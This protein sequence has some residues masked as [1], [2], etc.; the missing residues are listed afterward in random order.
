MSK[1][2]FFS[3]IQSTIITA[4]ITNIE[5]K[6]NNNI[7]TDNNEN[8]TVDNIKCLLKKFFN[9]LFSLKFE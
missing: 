3:L 5:E 1:C 9:D 8:K 6:E 2:K 4:G 7:K